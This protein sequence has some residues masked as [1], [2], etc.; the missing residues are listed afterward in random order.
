M[1]EESTGIKL[2]LLGITSSWTR[3]TPKEVDFTG[4]YQLLDADSNQKAQNARKIL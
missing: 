2:I 4:N 3:N 1:D